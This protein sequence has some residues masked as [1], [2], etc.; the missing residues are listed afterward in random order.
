MRDILRR[1]AA[2]LAIEPGAALVPPADTENRPTVGIAGL[3]DIPGPGE[4]P[5]IAA[6]DVPELTGDEV[7]FIAL[8]D[9]SLV[10]D[11]EVPDDTLA[12]LAEEIE[13]VL[14]PPY[15]AVAV[16]KDATLWAVAAQSVHVVELDAD[17]DVI[18]I[19]VVAGER[20]ATVDGEPKTTA[21]PELERL[22]EERGDDYALR[23][24]RID[25]RT[26]VVDVWPI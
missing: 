12:P 17:A 4:W 9:R 1:V 26:W 25:D 23:A 15:R 22:G 13:A 14:E 7:H 2:T 24:E 21:F 8:A 18:E 19:A 16:R 10:V 5:A 6:A 11:E 20:N 3:I